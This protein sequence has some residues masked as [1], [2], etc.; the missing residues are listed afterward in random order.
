M[1]KDYTFEKHTHFL[2]QNV[3]SKIRWYTN[4]TIDITSYYVH[5][6]VFLYSD[7]YKMEDIKKLEVFP[8]AT[9]YARMKNGCVRGFNK[10]QDS[11]YIKDGD[12]F[13]YAGVE[14]KKL[15]ET[16]NDI[17]EIETLTF[18]ELRTRTK[19]QTL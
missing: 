15:A 14:A 10:T 2:D 3:L 6:T 11:K 19:T 5:P 4:D 17:V 1:W 13:A 8:F 18:R 7:H 16:L 9:R 12:I